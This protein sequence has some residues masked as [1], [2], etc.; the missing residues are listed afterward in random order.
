MDLKRNHHFSLKKNIDRN[1]ISNK[2]I[3]NS[4]K[5][6]EN[7]NEN[8]NGNKKVKS[9]KLNLASLRF[10]ENILVKILKQSKFKVRTKANKKRRN[11]LIDDFKK[12]NNRTKK[13]YLS[14]KFRN[15]PGIDKLKYLTNQSMNELINRE[16]KLSFDNT[17]NI[18]INNKHNDN[19]KLINN[20]KFKTAERINTLNSSLGN[21]SKDKKPRTENTSLTLN[22]SNIGKVKCENNK[23]NNRFSRGKLTTHQR[24][25]NFYINDGQLDI[26]NKRAS[27]EANDNFTSFRKQNITDS[28]YNNNLY[29]YTQPNQ[30]FYKVIY[31]NK[32]PMPKKT[33]LNKNCNRM[34]SF[35]KSEEKIYNLI[36]SGKKS[37]T[38]NYE[39]NKSY[40][41]NDNENN[42]FHLSSIQKSKFLNRSSKIDR[43]IFKL[44]NPNGCFEE[45]VYSLKAGDK[46]ISFKNQIIRQR[47]QIEKIF[48]KNKMSLISDETL[49]KKY[50]YK[51]YSEANKRHNKMKYK[52]QI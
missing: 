11:D 38:N 29:L 27:T 5:T 52:E 48:Y 18:T 3:K 4:N 7:E 9:K 44:E 49:V 10:N 25:N 23:I 33:K 12:L 35:D 40:N 34:N 28:S 8:E 24:N 21:H 31:R 42:K 51:L 17:P 16:E 43:L 15:I 2:N 22:L 26:N 45:N 39:N 32:D 47:K 19:S 14:E 37:Y 6:I 30:C 20:P 36:T 50:I 41:P 46:Y 1:L 13:R